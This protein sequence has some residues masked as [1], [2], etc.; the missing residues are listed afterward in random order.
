MGS[1]KH[2]YVRLCFANDGVALPS[3]D[4]AAFVFQIVDSRSKRLSMIWKLLSKS[5]VCVDF[6]SMDNPTAEFLLLN[7]SNEKP[8]G[9]AEMVVVQM[10][11]MRAAFR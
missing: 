2:C 1:E 5:L 7:I 9:K 3:F 11:A 6:T 10:M 4:L 8:N